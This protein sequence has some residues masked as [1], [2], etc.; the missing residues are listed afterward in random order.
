MFEYD[1]ELKEAEEIRNEI[2]A[3]EHKIFTL[4]EE[5]GIARGIKEKKKSALDKIESKVAQ[6]LLLNGELDYKWNGWLIN[7]R[8]P[9][10]SVHIVDINI[11]D[12]R[13][14]RIKEEPDKNKIKKAIKSGEFV[15]G[16]ELITGNPRL[17]YT[18]PGMY[19]K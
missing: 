16:A 7:S 17:S 5:L 13:F 3:I 14:K 8:T 18:A 19:N 4:T 11:I 2:R 15:G 10:E 12:G 9:G 1:D 6:D